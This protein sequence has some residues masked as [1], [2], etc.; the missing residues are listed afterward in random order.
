MRVSPP[1][2]VRGPCDGGG[3]TSIITV[4]AALPSG[5]GQVPLTAAQPSAPPR[6]GIVVLHESREFGDSVIELI[7]S[8]AVEGWTVAAPHL[9]DRLPESVS[10]VFGDALFEDFDAAVAWLGESG[11]EPDRVGVLGFDE[12]GTAALLVAIN[13]R[14]GAAVSVAC[15]GIV[16]PLTPE[17]PPLVDAV[18]RVQ[19]P[20]LGL[21][22]DHDPNIPAHHIARLRE[23]AANAEAATLVVSYPG[24]EHRADEPQ[25]QAER[26]FADA[27][28]RIV[29]W[30]DSNLR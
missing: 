2:L 26:A 23:A 7:R 17:T 13:R 24:H 29:D 8:L 15:R 3:V 9:F 10:S 22:G 12:A 4:G 27:R 16:E 30:F 1:A 14:I 20:W 18:T 5:K 28:E 19:A 11:I 21:F 6:G 25:V